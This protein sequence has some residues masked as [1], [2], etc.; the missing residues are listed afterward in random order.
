MGLSDLHNTL[1]TLMPNLYILQFYYRVGELVEFNCLVGLKIQGARRIECLK[2]GL[3]SG[4]IPLC[5][6]KTAKDS[7]NATAEIKKSTEN[8]TASL[9]TS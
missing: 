7:N 6:R 1:R 9:T 2:S 8:E 5:I 3:W 4:A